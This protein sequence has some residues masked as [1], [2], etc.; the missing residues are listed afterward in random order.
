[1]NRGN[2]SASPCLMDLMWPATHMSDARVHANTHIPLSLRD[3]RAGQTTSPQGLS[4]KL[5]PWPSNFRAGPVSTTL[6][7][8]II[9][10][11]LKIMSAVTAY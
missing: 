10:L 2:E 6:T 1:M 3:V 4:I 7:E 8:I 5:E 11:V 9:A